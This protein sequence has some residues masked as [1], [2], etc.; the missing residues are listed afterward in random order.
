MEEAGLEKYPRNAGEGGGEM[1]G[2]LEAHAAPTEDLSSVPSTGIRQ[3]TAFHSF[4]SRGSNTLV[5]PLRGHTHTV[6]TNTDF[7]K[8]DCK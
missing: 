6:K 1:A 8:G 2:R 4:G 7:I 3:L 5:W